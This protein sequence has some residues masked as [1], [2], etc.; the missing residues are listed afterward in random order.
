L[1]KLYD[2]DLRGKHKAGCFTRSAVPSIP[3]RKVEATR[4][5]A[6][7]ICSFESC[8]R[9]V[10][11][12]KSPFEHKGI[13]TAQSYALYERVILNYVVASALDQAS[14]GLEPVHRAIVKRKNAREEAAVP[15]I[16]IGRFAPP[17]LNQRFKLFKL[18]S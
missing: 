2:P 6:V 1:R 7:E 9:G 16:I 17:T 4:L 11:N 13:G 3:Q 8:I 15:R 10:T 14:Y 18:L 5:C 12:G